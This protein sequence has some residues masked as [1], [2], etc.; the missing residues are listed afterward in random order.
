MCHHHNQSRSI[1][2]QKPSDE[3][4]VINEGNA[5]NFADYF[6]KLFN[7][8]SPFH[9]DDTVLPFVSQLD[10]FHHLAHLP[11]CGEVTEAKYRMKDGK[12]PGPTEITSDALFAM[13]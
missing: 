1:C 12:T 8:P 11:S 9:C 13:I 6:A 2:M 3:K 4:T 5:R 7:N 10:T